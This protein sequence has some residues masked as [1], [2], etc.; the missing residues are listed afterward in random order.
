MYSLYS[1]VVAFLD[2]LAPPYN[3][4]EGRDCTYYYKESTPPY[5]N[6][7]ASVSDWVHL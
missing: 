6:V 4:N 5:K 7:C 3:P 2:I 1:S